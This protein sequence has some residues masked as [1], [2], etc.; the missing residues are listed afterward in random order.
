MLPQFVPEILNMVYSFLPDKSLS[1]VVQLNKSFRY[2]ALYLLEERCEQKFSTVKV[3]I[4]EEECYRF[5]AGF[6]SLGY[7][8]LSVIESYSP[9]TIKFMERYVE[10]VIIG[11]GDDWDYIGT[12]EIQNFESMVSLLQPKRLLFSRVGFQHIVTAG[13]VGFN[14]KSLNETL[15]VTLG[16]GEELDKESIAFLQ[17]RVRSAK[18]GDTIGLIL[19]P[20]FTSEKAQMV[21]Q[22]VERNIHFLNPKNVSWEEVV[23]SEEDIN[24]QLWYQGDITERKT[25]E[26]IDHISIEN[27]IVLNDML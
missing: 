14:L 3:T 24:V 25:S 10:T 15:H 27:Y 5:I 4:P 6:Q 7:K 18:L 2:Q 23:D 21:K 16:F 9:E 13:V 17:S 22:F 1:H 20:L 8:N 12:S 11:M 19:G 26:W